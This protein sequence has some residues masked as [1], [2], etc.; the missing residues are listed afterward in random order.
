MSR[1]FGFPTCH[2]VFQL[3]FMRTLS[4]CSSDSSLLNMQWNVGPNCRSFIGSYCVKTIENDAFQ[5]NNW[6]YRFF[7][8]DIEDKKGRL[9]K[10]LL[11]CQ[12]CFISQSLI[13]SRIKFGFAEFIPEC[14]TICNPNNFLRLVTIKKIF[15]QIIASSKILQMCIQC[16]SEFNFFTFSFISYILNLVIKFWF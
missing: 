14:F 13:L 6:L 2:V 3:K 12:L 7:F 16:C 8:W 5:L 15:I 10:E 1:S 11:R 9:E 4:L